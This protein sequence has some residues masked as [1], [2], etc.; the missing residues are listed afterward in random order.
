MRVRGTQKRRAY[1]V[2]PGNDLDFFTG[3]DPTHDVRKILHE[4]ERVSFAY[5]RQDAEQMMRT[6]QI[7]TAASFA[8]R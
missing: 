8:M 1:V 2:G 7:A 5:M 4:C 3:G 6:K